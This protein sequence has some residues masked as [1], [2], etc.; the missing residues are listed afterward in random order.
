MDS[1]LE[2]YL[3]REG[4]INNNFSFLILTGEKHNVV[5]ETRKVFG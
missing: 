1:D 4:A 2:I 3:Q 5:W